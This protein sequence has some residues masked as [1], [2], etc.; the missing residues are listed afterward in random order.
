MLRCARNEKNY[1]ILL[2]QLWN[3]HPVRYLPVFLSLCPDRLSYLTSRCRRN[4]LGRRTV[5]STSAGVLK[6]FLA[7]MVSAWDKSG[8]IQIVVFIRAARAV[9]LKRHTY[10]I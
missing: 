7:A 3:R 10:R 1:F 6:E 8:M 5:P 2:R 4:R 9:R